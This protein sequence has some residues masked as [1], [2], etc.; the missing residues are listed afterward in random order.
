MIREGREES[1]MDG[2]GGGWNSLLIITE[3]KISEYD[4]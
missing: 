1:D 3:E 2:M 4:V